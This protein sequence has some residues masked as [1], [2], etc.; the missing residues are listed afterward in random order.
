MSRMPPLD[1]GPNS[2][3]LTLG[4]NNPLTLAGGAPGPNPTASAPADPAAMGG[5][6]EPP[7]PPA[8]APR[9]RPGLK[10]GGIEDAHFRIDEHERRL[11]ALEE[12]QNPA[13][14]SGLVTGAM[15]ALHGSMERELQKVLANQAADVEADRAVAK[16]LLALVEELRAHRMALA[17]PRV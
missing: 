4:G 13:H 15:H 9:P 3:E 16:A 11:A 5:G 14:V 2:G 7:P 8:R 1:S 12:G 17:T 6:M 10:A